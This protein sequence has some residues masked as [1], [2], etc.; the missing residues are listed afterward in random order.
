MLQ[1]LP[2]RQRRRTLLPQ[3]CPELIRTQ[4]CRRSGIL[5]RHAIQ[6]HRAGLRDQTRLARIPQQVA[7]KQVGDTLMVGGLLLAIFREEPFN[8]LFDFFCGL[9]RTPAEYD[10]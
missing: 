3:R 5:L 4:S 6:Q 8:L 1:S 10:V 2:P 7:Q 9:F